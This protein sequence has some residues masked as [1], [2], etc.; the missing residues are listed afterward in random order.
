MVPLILKDFKIT[1]KVYL[2]L[3]GL[4]IFISTMGM[5]IEGSIKVTM[6]YILST[7]VLAY[8]PHIYVTGKDWKYKSD[9]LLNSLAI[10]RNDLVSAKY[11]SVFI[12]IIL[13]TLIVFSYTNLVKGF[14][15]GSPMSYI[16][17][18]LTISI[19]IIFFSV[20]LFMTFLSIG[21]AQ[22]FNQVFYI[23][24]ILLPTLV[25]RLIDTTTLS[26]KLS[27]IA[28]F[29]LTTILVVIFLLSLVIFLASM[30]FSQIVYNQKE[31]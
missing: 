27:Y 31:F 14:L 9:I 17:V 21:K 22:Y 2:F 20:N 1:G 4:I 15:V 23:V 25:S 30:R 12:H 16:D 8:Y 28:N 6:L 3:I 7:I 10:K 24:L 13:S 18:L 19:L 5:L 11:I 29:N 26:S